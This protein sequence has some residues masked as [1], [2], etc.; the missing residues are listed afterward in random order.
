MN[1][2]FG[3]R[4]LKWKLLCM[5]PVS[6]PG[7]YNG[8]TPILSVFM[9]SLDLSE[10][11][12]FDYTLQTLL[13]NL[14]HPMPKVQQLFLPSSCQVS[15]TLSSTVFLYHHSLGNVHDYLLV[16]FY[17]GKDRDCPDDYSVKNWKYFNLERFNIPADWSI[18]VL[19]S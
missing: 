4:H 5:L 8:K 14:P 6:L 11:P 18:E 1:H 9:D 2:S 16:T 15:V 7:F 17:K 10:R 19:D 3:L 13:S 12:C